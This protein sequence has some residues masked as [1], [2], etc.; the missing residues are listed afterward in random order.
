MDPEE[1]AG[2]RSA[3]PFFLKAAVML[4]GGHKFAEQKSG[5]EIPQTAKA[6]VLNLGRTRKEGRPFGRP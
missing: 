3:S 6:Q 1:V 4:Q 5:R 2:G